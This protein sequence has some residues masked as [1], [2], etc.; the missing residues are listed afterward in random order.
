M[1]PGR[2]L[3]TDISAL[4]GKSRCAMSSGVAG[5]ARFRLRGRPVEH[6]RSRRPCFLD[7]KQL[8]PNARCCSP[9]GGKDLQVSPASRRNSVLFSK[10]LSCWG[11]YESDMFLVDDHATHIGMH[12]GQRSVLFEEEF[13]QR[14]LP[15][16]CF[17]M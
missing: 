5:R 6:K 3:R 14:I 2:L 9:A 4:G 13:Y 11:A 8:D 10:A 15:C 7:G 17:R 16:R 1:P 12:S